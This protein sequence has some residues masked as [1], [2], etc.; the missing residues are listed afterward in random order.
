[1]RKVEL[2]QYIA[3][4][5]ENVIDAFT[6]AKMLNGWWGVER[7][8]IDKRIGGLYTLAW[9]ITGNGFGYVSTGIIKDYDPEG[10]LFIDNFVYL[11]PEKPFFGP[12]SLLVQAHKKGSSTE[13]L[14]RQDGY[15]NGGEWEWYY[16][17][18]KQA[19]PVVVQ[20]LKN[21]LE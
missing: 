2:T 10:L 11:N 16:D 9:G 19:W 3:T 14:L 21:Y 20:N 15:Q 13:L 6:D 12:M 1:M 18:V 7:T 5:P 4:S 8:L 17:V